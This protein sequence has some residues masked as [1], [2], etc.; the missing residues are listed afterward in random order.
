MT[1]WTPFSE[2]LAFYQSKLK[3]CDFR[4]PYFLDNSRKWFGENISCVSVTLISSA[5]M[6]PGQTRVCSVLELQERI[7]AGCCNI[8]GD[9]WGCAGPGA[10]KR[11]DLEAFFILFIAIMLPKCLYFCIMLRH[12]ELTVVSVLIKQFT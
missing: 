11:R 2:T 8:R 6:T 4:I 3:G 10:E 5:G 1:H 9:L 12:D 7:M